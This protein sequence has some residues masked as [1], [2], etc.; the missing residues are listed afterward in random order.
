MQCRVRKATALLAFVV[1]MAVAASAF[2]DLRSAVTA[3]ACCVK[4]DYR[5]ATVGGPDDCCQHMGHTSRGATLGNPSS[6]AP[7]V[8]PTV[9]IFPSL[10]TAPAISSSGLLDIASAFKRPHDPPH[11]H[12]FS[13]LI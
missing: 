12:T 3:M 1:A 2:A 11:L 5:C 9:V 13:L 10:Y 8:P 4:T 7:I 6:A